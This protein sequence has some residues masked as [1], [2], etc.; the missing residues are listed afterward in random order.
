MSG[1][2]V[3]VRDTLIE[4]LRLQTRVNDMFT[5]DSDI[6]KFE[7]ESPLWP[8]AERWSD[9]S[10]F[11]TVEAANRRLEEYHF[12][13]RDGSRAYLPVGFMFEKMPDGQSV[14]RVYSDHHLVEDRSP[15]LPVK[16]DLHPWRSEQDV[17]FAYFNA[18]NNNKL[19]DVLDLFDTDGYFRHSNGE[20]FN[21]RDELRQDF[22]KMMGTTGIK[23]QYCQFTDDGTTCV[24][25]VYM[26]SGRPAIALYQRSQTPGRLHAVRIYL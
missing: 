17:L 5:G 12:I 24:A 16:A 7:T 14:V 6:G 18:L 4:R 25:E 8:N 3:S 9:I 21:G 11:N 22:S 13:P 23:I 20:T 2:N 19:E 26:P 1:G 10:L 15:I